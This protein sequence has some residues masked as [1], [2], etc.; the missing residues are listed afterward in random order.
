MFHN[1]LS[2][3]WC[4]R[5]DPHD[6]PSCSQLLRHELFTMNGWI[7]KFTADLRYSAQISVLYTYVYILPCLCIVFTVAKH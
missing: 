2:S 6:R 1:A 5:L 3:Q 4:L 7:P